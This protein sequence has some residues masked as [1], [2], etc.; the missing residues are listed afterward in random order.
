MGIYMNN[1]IIIIGTG[2][3]GY[4][5]AR[6]FRKHDQQTDLLIIT[7]D[8]GVFYPK[9]QLSTALTNKKTAETLATSTAE[10]MS[11]Q[12]N[13]IIRTRTR[14]TGIDINNKT[15]HAGDEKISY[16]KLILACGAQVVKPSLA[17]NAAND[18]LS[19]NHLEDYAVFEK[20]IADKKSI[21]IL[22]AG[23]IGCEFAN[24]L[25]NNNYQVHVIDPTRSPLSALIPEKIG[26]LLQAALEKNGVHFHLG[27]IAQRIDKT[28]HQYQITLSDQTILSA[29]T[30]IS[31]IGLRPNITLAKQIG[32]ATNRGI[33]VNRYLQTSHD[34][35]FALGDCA[36]VEGHVL[37][38]IAPILN[39]A[40]A[41]G[42]T[43]TGE[44]TAV[45]YPAMPVIVKTPIHP[46]VVCPP[47][48]GMQ[49]QWSVDA[50]AQNTKALFHNEENKLY[51]FVLTNEA[52]KERM[53]LTAQL[54]N[55]IEK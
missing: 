4:Q 34:D 28:E 38:Y 50:D 2:L 20:L 22:G 35:I 54:P 3:A 26:H 18:V 41:L 25:S 21:V 45:E 36:E 19:I 44:L 30:V 51:G 23:L 10:K 29:D 39:A 17:G 37:P 48:F 47:P 40:R 43:L 31:A 24:D 6:E 14:V 11:A 13:A 53:G 46:I 49:G 16:Q 8:E 9:P 55:L 52:V 7:A 1:P 27:R 12:L 32:L 42:K 5:L 15:I 33:V